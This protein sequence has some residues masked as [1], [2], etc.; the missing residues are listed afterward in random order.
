MRRYTSFVTLLLFAVILCICSC[1]KRTETYATDTVTDYLPLQ[2][3]KYIS[4]RLDSTLFLSF[5][6]RLETH[7][8]QVKLE[9][10]AQVQDNQG[11]PA[12][13]IYR[14][15]RDSAGTT[16]WQPDNTFIVTPLDNQIEYTEDNL[17]FIALHL[18]IKD[19]YTWKGNAYLPEEPYAALFDFQ[20][21]NNMRDWDYYYDGDSIPTVDIEDQTYTDV[22]S[23]AY[24]E[25]PDA[26]LTDT[27]PM[28]DTLPVSRSS[29]MAKYAKNI[30]LVY[31][32]F[33]MWDHQPN[34]TVIDPGDPN[35]PNHPA[36]YSY[37]PYTNGFVLRM[38][39][40][41]HN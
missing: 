41:D 38:W 23:V 8:Y 26:N 12:Y 24:T 36:V 7:S 6:K 37:D 27:I 4:Y 40:I 9:V 34:P 17:R 14:Y 3:G 29:Y 32:E 39:M 1:K 33:I 18:P 31:K 16:S 30:G 19:G 15:I 5:G 22:I 25:T 35:D 21:D 10:N 28:L 20:N 2:V 11:R 13:R